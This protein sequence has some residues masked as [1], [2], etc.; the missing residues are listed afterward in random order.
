M[1]LEET[2]AQLQMANAELKQMLKE[3][4]KSGDIN[5]LEETIA[6]LELENKRLKHEL[7]KK[8]KRSNDDK[9]Y[10]ETIALLELEKR[11]LKHYLQEKE[12]ELLQIQTEKMQPLRDGEKELLNKGKMLF[13]QLRAEREQLEEEKRAFANWKRYFD[14]EAK[15]N[16]VDGKEEKK[17]EESEWETE[18]SERVGAGENERTTE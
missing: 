3:K 2:I 12:K 7:H 16:Q 10:R 6:V 18:A 9:T 8:D 1:A 14:E 15:R 17:E 11:E 4:I 13:D 5:Y